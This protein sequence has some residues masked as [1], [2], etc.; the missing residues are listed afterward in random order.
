MKEG[1]KEQLLKA[2]RELFSI[3]GLQKTTIGDLTEAVGV[4]TGTFY[5]YFES[6]EHLYFTVLER[7]ETKL[8]ERL[9]NLDFYDSKSKRDSFIKILQNSL[10]EVRKNPLL[11]QLYKE[12]TYV[13]LLAKLP[14]KIVDEHIKKDE[15]SFTRL[16]KNWQ[17]LGVIQ[18]QDPKAVSSIIRALFTL[19]LHEKEIGS[20]YFK[21]TI[22]WYIVRVV[23][24][25]MGGLDS[26]QD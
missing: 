22:N 12:E 9:F 17:D 14:K 16:I 6:K 21:E 8:Q 24:G 19:T 11:K 15:D 25:L 13:Q 5:N 23:D 1:I 10:S 3:Y 20:D 7:E 4:A 18:G 26:V 2:G